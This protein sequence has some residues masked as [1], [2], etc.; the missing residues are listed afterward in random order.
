MS[1][2]PVAASALVV[3]DHRLFAEVLATRM[4]NEGTVEHVETVYAL[5]HARAVLN[6]LRPEVVLLDRE[7]AGD[8]GLR[9]LPHLADL[10]RRP[11]VL[12]VSGGFDAGDVVDALAAGVDGW[13]GKDSGMPLLLEAI[14]TV[15]RGD[16]YLPAAMT[17]CVVERLLRDGRHRPQET[18]F[19]DRLSARET[20]VLR[21][22]VAGMTRSEAADR[23]YVSTNTIRTHVQN[24]LKHAEVH[25]T[26]A[27]VAAARELGVPGID[28]QPERAGRAAKP[29]GSSSA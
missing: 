22:L 21:C 2:R 23:L 11:R 25:S 3:D 26:G 28:E 13:I 29:L 17:R 15:L 16:L 1:R 20:D 14:A 4:R 5:G 19:V 9:L 18:T 8:D 10:P 12:V 24:L 7:V 6:V 27:L